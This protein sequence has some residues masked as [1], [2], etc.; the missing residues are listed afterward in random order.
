[1]KRVLITFFVIVMIQ[2]QLAWGQWT[3]LPGGGAGQQI[4]VNKNKV[5]I[6]GTDFAIYSNNGTSWE[7]YPGR[8]KG[9]DIAVYND[10]SCI[11]GTDYKIYTYNGLGWS[12]VPGGGK[13]KRISVDTSGRIWIIGIDNAIYFL[14]DN[15]WQ[16][17]PGKGLGF[18]IA[19]HNN[20]PIIIGTDYKIYKGNGTG[21]SL[22]AGGGEGKRISVDNLGKLWLIGRD[23]SIYFYD[24]TNN[25]WRE[26]PGKGI[27]VCAGN[28]TTYII[29]QDYHIYN[30]Q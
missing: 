8:G 27:D 6:I 19:V 2:C 10:F 28:C 29:G 21:W 30:T 26:V 1:M 17:Y 18:D 13:G 20:V 12:L 14:S 22:L 25:K 7:S 3:N 11:I 5:W 4:A 9:F 16:P 15:K 23:E 24:E